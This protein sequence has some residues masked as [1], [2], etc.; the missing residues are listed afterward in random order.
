MKE[1][2]YTIPVNEAYD[3]DCE[4]PMCLL[5]KKLERD[6]LDYTLGAAMMEPDFR[7]NSNKNGFCRHHFSM[8]FDIP[9]KLPLALVLDT[10][11]DEIRKNLDTLSK[12]ANSLKKSKG[13]LFKKTGAADFADELSKKAEDI[14]NGCIV[15][16][17]INHTMERYADVLLY[18]WINDEKFKDKFNRS[19]GLC[20]KHMRLL[21]RIAPKSLNDAQSAK[22]LSYMFAKQQ[23]ELARIQEDIHKFTLKFDYRNKD[24]DWGTAQDAPI[25]AIEKIAGYIKNDIES[26]KKN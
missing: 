23:Q 20:L 16:D 10:H 6:T 13:G 5:E 22:F 4:C 12:S 26:S 9:N 11:L 17:K 7:E 8:L 1:Q 18:M 2:I 21:C 3:Q 15:C 24:M 14:E 19:K 25:R